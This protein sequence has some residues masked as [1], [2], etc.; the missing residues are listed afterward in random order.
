MARRDDCHRGRR[1]VRLDAAAGPPSV[2]RALQHDR[3][4]RL[5]VT[6]P[7]LGP[8]FRAMPFPAD[9]FGLFGGSDES[10]RFSERSMVNHVAPVSVHAL[11]AAWNR[12][13]GS[14]AEVR[15]ENGGWKI[16]DDDRG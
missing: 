1:L 11:G 7:A 10:A 15:M 5:S 3:H 12:G 14:A 16:E 4:Q 13:S 2:G 8:L 6:S 9:L